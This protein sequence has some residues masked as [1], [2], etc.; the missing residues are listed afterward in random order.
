MVGHTNGE[1]VCT[2]LGRRGRSRRANSLLREKISTLLFVR[3]QME[4][5]ITRYP[6]SFA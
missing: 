6:L 4:D 1:L 3:D 5:Q 2:T